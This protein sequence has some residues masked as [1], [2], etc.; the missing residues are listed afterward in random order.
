MYSRGSVIPLFIKQIREG[1]PLTITDGSMTRFLLP[2]RDALDLVLFAF[3]HS[4]PG[5]IFIKK[6]PAC[7]VDDLV[8][9][10]KNMFE[11]DTP[12]RQIGMRHGEKIYETLATREELVRA[13]DLGDYYRVP[14]DDRDLNYG[15][16]VT[17]GS[18]EEA[19]VEDYHSHNTR[20]L[21]VAE[22]ESLLM[23]LPEV[24]KQIEEHGAQRR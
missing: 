15:K 3:E 19:S 22:I 13:D 20:R 4:R 1:K 16:Y 17:E 23:S 6:A 14:M 24:V 2:L 5:D 21:G 18:T 8:A 12:V 9:A 7:T 10:L 11:A